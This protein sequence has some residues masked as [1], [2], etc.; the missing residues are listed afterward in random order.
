MTEKLFNQILN[1]VHQQK[2]N[3]YLKNKSLLC[4]KTLIKYRLGSIK[5]RNNLKILYIKS[6]FE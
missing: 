6:E 4:Y 2:V 3:F 5:I 1:Y